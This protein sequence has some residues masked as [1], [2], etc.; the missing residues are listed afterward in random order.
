MPYTCYHHES[1][2]LLF[3]NIVTIFLCLGMI[4]RPHNPCQRALVFPHIR[5]MAHWWLFVIRPPWST[6]CLKQPGSFCGMDTC[7]HMYPCF[8]S[9]SLYPFFSICFS[10]LFFFFLPFEYLTLVP[11][12]FST[13]QVIFHLNHFVNSQ[14]CMEQ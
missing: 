13:F 14:L 8:T 3:T 7:P 5:Q 1:S 9:S 4:N 10:F 12:Y 11:N 2:F 6:L